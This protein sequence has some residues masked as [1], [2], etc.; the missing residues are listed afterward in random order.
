MDVCN[1]VSCN[2][3]RRLAN[4]VTQDDDWLPL[5][6]LWQ[7]RHVLAYC[8][9]GCAHPSI[10]R[11][12]NPIEVIIDGASTDRVVFQKGARNRMKLTSLNDVTLQ[13]RC[14][15]LPQTVCT[16]II[17]T[18]V[19]CNRHRMLIPDSIK[20]PHSSIN[21]GDQWCDRLPASIL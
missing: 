9:A 16:I 7:L 8:K 13:M 11:T 3:I 4:H 5:P 15:P 14:P 2:C 17:V 6:L 20:A 1:D 18:T 21:I 10:T 12:T 19:M